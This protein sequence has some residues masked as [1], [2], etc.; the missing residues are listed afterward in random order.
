MINDKEKRNKEINNNKNDETKETKDV[1][2]E[3]GEN[4]GIMKENKIKESKKKKD[5]FQEEDVRIHMKTPAL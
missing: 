1:S 3:K 4:E 2:R 5:E